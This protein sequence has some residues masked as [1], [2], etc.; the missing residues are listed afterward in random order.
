MKSNLNLRKKRIFVILLLI[1]FY[2]GF[3]QNTLL[4][5]ESSATLI[6]SG[7]QYFEDKKYDEAIDQYK[8]VHRNDSNYFVA[9]L[10]L[11]NTYLTT[12]KDSLGLSYCNDLLKLKND[13][14]P[15]I[16]V[17]KGN[18]L[19]NLK[20]QSEA[21]AVYLQGQKDYPLNHSFVYEMGILNLRKKNYSEAYNWFVKSAKLNPTHAL[22]HFQ[23][24]ILAYRQNNVTASML[25]IQ[26][27]FMCDVSSKRAQGL[28]VDL[29][30]ISKMELES[31]TLISIPQF[32][33]ENDFSELESIIKSKVALG[34]KYKSKTDLAYDL[35]KQMQLVIENIGKYKDVKGFYNEF[36][37]KFFS[38]LYAKKHMEPYLYYCLSGM[39]LEKVDKWMERN[40]TEVNEF[41][42]WSYMYICQNHGNFMENLNGKTI[43]VP[44]WYSENRIVAAGAKNSNSEND[45]YWNYYFSNGIKKSE[46]EFKKG[47]KNGLW[48][49]YYKTGGIKEETVFEMGVEK[50]NKAYYLNTNMKYELSVANNKIE[51]PVK[52]Y[53]PNGNIMYIKEYKDGKINGTESQFYRNGN[54]KY[55]IRN[56][57][58]IYDG[59]LANY[60]DNG[61]P[62]LK[63]TLVKSKRQGAAKEFYNNDAS[64]T[65]SEGSYKDSE[66]S[67][68]WKFFHQNGK[69]S[70]Q[71]SYDEDGRKTGEWKSYFD[72]GI[73]SEIELYDGG[74]LNGL[75]K[76]YDIDGVLWQEF[77]YKKGKMLEYKAYKKDGSVIAEYKVNGKNFKVILYYPNGVKRR[78]GAISDG[79]LD[80]V[81]NDY[82]NFGV[83]KTETNYKDGLYQGKT[84]NYHPNGKVLSE[85]NY[86][87]NSQNGLYRK[88]FI[89]GNVD[90]EG[91]IKNGDRDGYWIYYKTDKTIDRIYYY[92]DG[93]IDGWTSHYDVNGKIEREELYSETCLIKVVYYDTLGNIMQNVD[94]LKG[95]GTLDKK[96]LAGKLHMHKEFS[97][98][99]I[100][101]DV[102]VYYAD[103][104]VSYSVKYVNGKEEGKGFSY[105]ELGRKTVETDYFNGEVDGKQIEY[106]PDGKVESD[107][108]YN[109]GD[110]HGKAIIYFTNGKVY[111]DMTYSYSEIEG[112]S[113]V[114]DEFGELVYKRFF[115]DDALV[116]FTYKDTKGN[117]VKP[118]ELPQG[119]YKA[120][121]YFQNG[122]KS[123]EADYTNGDLNGKRLVYFSNGQLDTEDNF[124]FGKSIG[125]SKAYYPSGKLKSKEVYVNGERHGTFEFYR[126]NGKLEHIT[127]YK[128]GQKHGWTIYYDETGKPIKSLLYYND[129]SILAK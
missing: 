114:Y 27:Y 29:E 83:L 85:T 80:G 36:Y 7:D 28:V 87:N 111:K 70:S 37:G 2:F 101:G 47:L 24:G 5:L 105:D 15:T 95:S 3:S 86:E 45:G 121:C 6:S 116:N 38:E 98:D 90:Y 77:T 55:T 8:K 72:S 122:K 46:G 119:N 100:E 10:R 16:L 117:F 120:V 44:H 99:Y 128:L 65:Y 63:Y 66:Y 102:K 97:K 53:Y 1:Q 33:N 61:K 91:M 67:G 11:L 71:G 21:E 103:G 113:S 22:S 19:D 14:T 51:G 59:E 69:L 127:N 20:K 43:S 50:V 32:E 93:E 125:D 26:Y 31:D 75:Q 18:F 23:L 78:E 49:F 108:S 115:V 42:N 68:E 104:T 64:S 56:V 118:M 9:S 79:E 52:F 12:D 30:K 58:D 17:Y 74:R 107:F 129:E 123:L 34:E 106:Y 92:V 112:E 94:L 35:T 39:K 4:N 25:A 40:K 13:I 54:K 81:W 82:T 57:D 60:F 76:Y 88:Y 62:Y 124:Y 109:N 126:E 41:S 48:K 96:N 73:L 84:I 110:K 89:D